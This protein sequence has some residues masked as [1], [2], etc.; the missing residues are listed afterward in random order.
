MHDKWQSPPRARTMR[1]FVE[2]FWPIPGWPAD[3]DNPAYE[4]AYKRER[5]GQ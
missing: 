2:H 3:W 1:W 5:L 4:A